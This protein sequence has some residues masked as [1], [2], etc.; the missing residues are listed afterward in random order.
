MLR[1]NKTR[2]HTPRDPENTL[3][4]V[5]FDVVCSEFH[6]SLLY[7]G[8]ELVSLFGLDHDVIHVGLNGP[9]DEIPETLKHATLVHRPLSLRRAR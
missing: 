7:V 2:Q 8:Y 5:K 6:E 1:D 9:P 4:W 3:S